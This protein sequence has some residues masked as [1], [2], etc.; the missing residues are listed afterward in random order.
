[1]VA[2]VILAI[3]NTSPFLFECILRKN[4]AKL[5]TPEV[6]SKYGEL[7]LGLKPDKPGVV[8]HSFVFMVR[9]SLFIALTFAL[10]DQPSLQVHLMIYMTV[11]YVMYLGYADF[12]ETRLVKRLEM[13]NESV[14]ILIQYQ[15]VLLLNLVWDTQMRLHIGTAI[16]VLT[17]CL[18]ALN[19]LIIIYSSLG[20]LCRKC[21]LKCLRKKRIAKLRKLK[22]A[23]AKEG[24]SSSKYFDQQ[25]GPRRL[26][27]KQDGGVECCNSE[28][29]DQFHQLSEPKDRLVSIGLIQLTSQQGLSCNRRHTTTGIET[30]NKGQKISRLLQAN[31]ITP[32]HDASKIR[33]NEEIDTHRG[34]IEIQ[35]FSREEYHKNQLR[36]AV[37]QPSFNNNFAIRVH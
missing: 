5:G 36:V 35:D 31:K 25:S 28:Q 9:R 7:Y 33:D 19:F 14:F 20:P 3:L 11:F 13:T 32:Q 23:G 8:N 1:M 15:F 26:A 6:R 37:P 10:F 2:S 22:Q 27:K 18:L 21:Y 30:P 12:F 4:R 34:L 16:I 29:S 24:A 17:S